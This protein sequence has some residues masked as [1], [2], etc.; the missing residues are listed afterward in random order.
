MSSHKLVF[1]MAAMTAAGSAFAWQNANFSRSAA[2]FVKQI[3]VGINIGNTLDVP[4]GDETEWGNAKITPEL[5]ALY[6]AKKFDAVR[7]PISWRRQFDR[8][9]PKHDVKPEFMARIREV[10]D[11]VIAQDMVAIVNIHHDGGDD[12][13]P[14][15]WLTIDGEHEDRANAILGDV[16]KQISAQFRDYDERL[17]FEAFNEVR[18][19]KRYAGPS[20]RQRGQED[21]VGCPQYFDT[22]N[23]YA[24][25]F[26]DT[27]RASGGKNAKRYVMIPTY[28][29]CFQESTCAGWKSPNPDDNR[30]IA[31]IHCYEPGDFCLWGNRTAY[32]ANHVQQRLGMF[33]GFFKKHFTDKGIPL[34]LGEINA[35]LRFYDA[36]QFQPNDDARVRWAAH[37]AREAKKYGF[38]CFIWESGGRKSMGLIDRQ[39]IAWSHEE[40][41]DAFVMAARGTLTE[42]KLEELCA[43][44]KVDS[45]KIWEKGDALLKWK[46]DGDNYANG[47]GQTMG[48]EGGNG[49]GANRKYISSDEQGNL[50]FNSHGQGGNMVQQ[51]FWA[52]QSVTAVRTYKSYVKTH[53]DLSLRGKKLCFSLTAAKGRTAA[54]KGEFVIPG[55]KGRVKFGADAGSDRIESKN[56]VPA[57]VEVELPTDAKL[58]PNGKGIGVEMW[59]FPGAWGSNQPLDCKLGPIEIK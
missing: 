16:W 12:G 8:D 51:Q 41:A 28:A 52:D 37:Y 48:F 27:V 58:D 43:K 2:D 1:A 13:W 36:E 57:R 19:A 39:K 20:G 9:D 40:V 42:A 44:V 47:W 53:A 33:F 6:K 15:A 23:R 31:T 26:Y 22:V 46:Y 45:N 14:G 35:D 49:N 38:P 11:M 56:G 21:W 5:I 29:A 24:K 54:I 59:V 32:D 10:V 34:I 18:K 25:T 17:V 30:V 4:A 50:V 7:I 55:V 3:D